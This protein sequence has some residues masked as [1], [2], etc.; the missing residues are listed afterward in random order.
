MRA[1]RVEGSGRDAK[2]VLA[3]APEPELRDDEVLIRVHATAV[4]H[5][6]LLQRR[7]LYPPPPGASEILGLECAG[8]VETVGKSVPT[9]SDGGFAVGDRVMALLPGGGYAERV[10]VHAGSVMRVPASLSDEEAAGIPEVA[11]TVHLNLFQ[12]ADVR[13][14]DWV[15]VHGGGS[16]I[17]TAAICLVREAGAHIIVTCGS[18]EK[19]ARARDLGA[20]LA[21][22]YHAGDFSEAV[23]EAS[24][25]G[26]AA[27]LDSIGAPYWAQHIRCLR[28][29]G[30]LILIG[31]RG[32]TKVEANLAP[33]V[34]KRIRVI[35]ST[36]RALAN[37][38]K[39]EIVRRFLAQFGTALEAGR[40]RFPIDRVL[41]LSEAQ[42][43]HAIVEASQHFG[44]VVLRNEDF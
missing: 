16:G 27:I 38:R 13:A 26:V 35:G 24:G 3:E 23:V 30:S 2:L 29:D 37:E 11:L 15:L 20:D 25:G 6:D 18:D 8:V 4:N 40:V 14:E 10:A 43:A 21:L 9:V 5:A 42:Q 12:L 33:L 31:L 19:C 1:I 41:P 22:D 34:G 28:P 32:G 7:G 36:L 17:G 39:A 44:K